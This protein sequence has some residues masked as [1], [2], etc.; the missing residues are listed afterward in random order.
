[1]Q[2]FSEKR[3]SVNLPYFKLNKYRV[4]IIYISVNFS[5]CPCL[6]CCSIFEIGSVSSYG[7]YSALTDSW[8][9]HQKVFTHF[10]SSNTIKYFIVFFIYLLNF[11]LGKLSICSLN[12][13]LC[14]RVCL[15]TW[16]SRNWLTPLSSTIFSL[17][18]SR[19]MMML[20]SF[21]NGL[22]GSS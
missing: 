11:I 5:I 19:Y 18:M 20:V 17:I 15:C 16:K 21:T 2:S 6:H 8:M 9:S 22:F 7:A 14:Y 10:F 3:P 13:C 4:A 12:L 1:M